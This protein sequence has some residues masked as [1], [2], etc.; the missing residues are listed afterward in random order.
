MAGETDSAFND[1]G[2]VVLG[3]GDSVIVLRKGGGD[4]AWTVPAPTIGN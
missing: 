1:V 3:E 2:D 4:F